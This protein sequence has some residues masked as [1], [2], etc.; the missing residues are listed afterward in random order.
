MKINRN[1]FLFDF[2][3]L[4]GFVIFQIVLTIPSH[5]NTYSY[6]FLKYITVMY[7]AYNF[8][9]SIIGGIL[10]LWSLFN[11]K[12]AFTKTFFSIHFLFFTIFP[13]WIFILLGG[14]DSD[15]NF[16]INIFGVQF[17]TYQ[18]YKFAITNLFVNMLGLPMWL[19][20]YTFSRNSNYVFSENYVSLKL[21]FI[22]NVLN[23]IV[24]LFLNFMMFLSLTLD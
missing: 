4:I 22:S 17:T 13:L 8:I 15:I 6:F 23:Q 10:F 2:W 16:I 1:I 3:F 21:R 11:K 24:I 9:K 20:Y 5:Y 18:F 19:F 7:I 14:V 12:I